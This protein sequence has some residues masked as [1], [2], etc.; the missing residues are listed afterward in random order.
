M[1]G[2]GPLELIVSHRGD[3]QVHPLPK[4]GH[5]ELG[6]SE[7]CTVR[8]DHSGIS[9]HHVRL[10][11]GSQLEVEDLGSANGTWLFRCSTFDTADE[12]AQANMNRRL[13]AGE[14]VPWRR[15]T[16]CASARWWWSSG[17]RPGRATKPPAKTTASW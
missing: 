5:V 4:S 12:T 16:R 11:I 14:R 1:K 8:L 9:R 2:G 7:T 17:A 15:A 10:Y 13:N 6:R 3:R